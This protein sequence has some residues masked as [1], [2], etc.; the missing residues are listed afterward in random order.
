MLSLLPAVLFDLCLAG[1]HRL[2]VRAGY[3]LSAVAIGLHF[4][5]L[6]GQ[7]ARYHR[8]GLNLITIGFVAL[9]GRKFMPQWMYESLERAIGTERAF[10]DDVDDALRTGYKQ[11]T[12]TS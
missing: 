6:I 2:L 7:D 1:R 12:N 3:G 5:E 11:R 8:W 10:Q 9:T 4:A